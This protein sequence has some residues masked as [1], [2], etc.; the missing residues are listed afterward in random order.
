MI[1]LWPCSEPL[2]VSQTHTHTHTHTHKYTLGLKHSISG[3]SAEVNCFWEVWPNSAHL[4]SLRRVWKNPY[5]FLGEKT[6]HTIRTHTHTHKHTYHL[7]SFKVNTYLGGELCLDRKSYRTTIDLV[8]AS[9]HRAGLWCVGVLCEHWTLD[10]EALL[11]LQRKESWP[12]I[13]CGV[14]CKAPHL[15]CLT[16]A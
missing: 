15:H 9:K 2:V 6:N 7:G 4:V 16:L 13:V 3:P 14:L 10:Q 5:S 11:T 8:S 12:P 1:S